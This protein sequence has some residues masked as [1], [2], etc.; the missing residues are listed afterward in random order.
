MYAAVL[1]EL[2]VELDTHLSEP[3]RLRSEELPVLNRRLAAAGLTQITVRR[4]PIV[5]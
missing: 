1:E 3:N 5:D 4:R 2:S